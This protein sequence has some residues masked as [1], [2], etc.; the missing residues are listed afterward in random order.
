MTTLLIGCGVVGSSCTTS[1]ECP[2][3]VTYSKEFQAKAAE[4]YE[5]LPKGSPV[6]TMIT[7]YSKTRD[8]CR[9]LGSK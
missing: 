8:A 7:D 9:A 2:P 6:K 4:Q 1:T 3:L 5:A